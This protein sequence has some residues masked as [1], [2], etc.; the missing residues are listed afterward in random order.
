M[1]WP[2]RRERVVAL[3]AALAWAFG[4]ACAGADTTPTRDVR[5]P[6]AGAELSSA[7]G[8][9]IL[10][11]IPDCGDC[12]LERVRVLVLDPE[13]AGHLLATLPWVVQDARGFIT[14]AEP[15]GTTLL[16]FDATGRFRRAVGRRGR[17]PGE[18]Q[19]AHG[20]FV[21]PGDSLYVVADA[22]RVNVYDPDGTPV[23]QT[24]LQLGSIP[25][26]AATGG[27]F[28]A[29]DEGRLVIGQEA[30]M[31]RLLG[32]P[33]RLVDRE[34]GHLQAFGVRNT[35]SIGITCRSLA[36]DAATQSLWAAEAHG[37][38]LEQLG[39]SADGVFRTVRQIGVRAP[40]LR[41]G[42]APLMTPEAL[43]A[44]LA[45][46]TVRRVDVD[47][48]R[49]PERFVQ[50]PQAVL[51]N[52]QADS[53][54]RLWLAWRVPAPGWDTVTLRYPLPEEHTL[55]DE[56][57]DLLWHTVVDVIDPRRARLLVR[58]TFPFHGHLAAAGVLAHPAYAATGGPEVTL[59]QLR[60]HAPE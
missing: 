25:C 6:R 46:A 34:G 33:M 10:G 42:R 45:T 17:G 26:L 51:R 54:G 9:T 15:T 29:L 5:L 1:G 40:W 4:A 48:R 13:A 7:T 16:T 8:D 23:R 14:L 21:A 18:L 39:A 53:A 49:R 44:E 22:R 38:R 2:A 11:A 58:D 37:Y 19:A 59:H 31:D 56:L 20:L 30:R 60:L 3:A 27:L 47:I 57:D 41:D 35:A 36:W 52:M 28:V 55:S 32:M 24:T 12:R 43:E 50:P